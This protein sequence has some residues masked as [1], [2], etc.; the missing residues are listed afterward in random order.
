M[1]KARKSDEEI[2]LL[3]QATGIQDQIFQRMIA[4]IR[5]G[6]RQSDV[7]ALARYESSRFGGEQGVFLCRSA[8][9]GKPTPVARGPHFDRRVL[10]AGDYFSLLIEN[11]APSGFYAEL[12]RTIVLGR[13]PQSLRDAFDIARDAQADMAASLA[14]GVACADVYARHARYMESRGQQAGRRITA[15][16]QGYDLVERPLLRDDET[17]RV[18]DGMFFAIHPSASLD[19]NTA[20]TCDNFLTGPG[21][22]W[23]HATP[24]QVFE[25]G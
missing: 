2:A 18:E 24:K 16:G 1:L 13:A 11:N 12:G 3:R 10:E 25:I 4:Q 6:M 15:H 8:P 9:L 7:V 20:F 5:P 21:G 17:M 14:D 19:Q 22:G 23:M